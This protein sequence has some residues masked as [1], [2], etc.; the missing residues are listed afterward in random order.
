MAENSWHKP[1]ENDTRNITRTK[2]LMVFDHFYPGYKAGGPIQSLANLVVLLEDSYDITVISSAYDLQSKEA[3]PNILID[4]WNSVQLPGTNKPIKI[5]YAGKGKPGKRLYGLLFKEID[6]S[7]VY[8]NGMFSYHYLLLPL[9]VLHKRKTNIRVIVCPRG[10][11]Q[12]GALALKATKKK[13]YLKWLKL[14]GL[15]KQVSWHATNDEE[16]N[17]IRKVFG[18]RQIIRIAS[19]VPKKPLENLLQVK[20]ERGILRLVY[21]SLI[22]EKK[23]LLQ[24]IEVVSNS[25]SGVVLDIYG[26]AKDLEYWEQCKILINRNPGKVK[27]MGEAR[28]EKVQQIFSNY[29]AS[30]LLTRGENFGHALY[31]SLSAARPVITSYFTPWK[32]LENKKAGWNVDISDTKSISKLLN[33]L[34]HLNTNSFDE[35]CRGAH[36]LSMAYFSSAAEQ[37]Q[38]NELFEVA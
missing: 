18:N 5:W 7:V 19:N 15:L 11:L 28:P 31:E 21:L 9:L 20:K 10:M 23:N 3:Y 8:L 6:P 17:D 30:I 1:V 34:C 4:G 12:A 22:A 14:S 37:Q 33:R 25:G 16:K 38:Y 26:P 35:Y 24:L 2:L 13:A 27:Y 29:D 36:L 32:E